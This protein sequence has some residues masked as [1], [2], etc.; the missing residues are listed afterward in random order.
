[1]LNL[2]YFMHRLTLVVD[3]VM[4]LEALGCYVVHRVR[5][6][7]SCDYIL[8]PTMDSTSASSILPRALAVV[9]FVCRRGRLDLL[10][11][12]PQF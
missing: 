7:N 4:R 6:L 8:H 10:Y 3:Q 1:M 2:C 12:R 5:L 9:A 11:L